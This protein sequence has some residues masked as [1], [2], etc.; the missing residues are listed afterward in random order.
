M[1]LCQHRAVLFSQAMAGWLVWSVVGWVGWVVTAVHAI[2]YSII[3]P[4][5]SD[6]QS[7]AGTTY[8]SRM[9]K[10]SYEL[11]PFGWLSN[12]GTGAAGCLLPTSTAAG[13]GLD[14]VV[15]LATNWCGQPP[16][17]VRDCMDGIS[18]SLTSTA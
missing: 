18:C 9:L 11:F 16:L 3:N 17:A 5:N 8:S 6:A 13:W 14:A 2:P 10:C 4:R 15:L 7:L 12:H 1:G